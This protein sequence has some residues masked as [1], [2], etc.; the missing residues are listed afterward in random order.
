MNYYVTDN[1]GEYL[2]SGPLKTIVQ[3]FRLHK[4]AEDRVVREC[5]AKA[6][7]SLHFNGKPNVFNA[8]GAIVRPT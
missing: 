8:I 2:F 6:V 3:V 5:E 1:H 7:C 4:D